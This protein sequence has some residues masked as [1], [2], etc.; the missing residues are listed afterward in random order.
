LNY[1]RQHEIMAEN[2]KLTG[3]LAYF[4]M[5]GEVVFIAVFFFLF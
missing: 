4:P 3:P 1:I 5:E 2:R